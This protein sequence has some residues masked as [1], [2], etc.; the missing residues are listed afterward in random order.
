[1]RDIPVI[2]SGP[3]VCALL[4]EVEKPGTG[5]TMTRRLLKAQ[6]PAAP[7]MDAIYPGNVARHDAPYFDAYC[8]AP[9]T[10]LNPRGMSRNWCWWTR[11]DRQCLPTIDA[12]FVPGD[13]LW[14]R[15]N[16]ACGACAPGKPS[17]WSPGFWRREQGSPKNPNGLWYAADGLA[18][19]RTI[20]D[21]GPWVPSI[22]MP[23]WVSRLT[24]IVTGVKIEP[25][26]SITREDAIAEGLI[27]EPNPQIEQFYR[28]PPPYDAGMWLSTPAA[29][30][31]LWRQLNGDASWDENPTVVAV[32][33]TVHKR[34]LLDMPQ[35]A[36]AA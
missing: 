16:V 12:R 14:V 26:Q 36:E 25:V 32:T 1:M 6:M 8:N 31:W 5:K 18:P 24:L 29:F 17:H 34:N 21:R 4:R 20:T 10:A 30:G 11:D 27:P 13:R 19:E 2:F 15:E 23:R 35:Q 22:H 28:W 7:S 3:M 33:F 9:R